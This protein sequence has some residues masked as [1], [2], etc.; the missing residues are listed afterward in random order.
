MITALDPTIAITMAAGGTVL[1]INAPI[2]RAAKRNESFVIVA[3]ET[4]QLGN[5]MAEPTH[6]LP[7]ETAIAFW[8]V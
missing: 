6:S 1:G 8:S 3:F 5:V 4:L 7:S 2:F